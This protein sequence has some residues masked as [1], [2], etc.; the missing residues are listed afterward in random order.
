MNPATIFQICS[1]IALIGWLLLIIVSPFW[2][3]VDKFIISI[4][5]TIFALV[6][7]W[8]IATNFYFGDIQKFNS[9]EGVMSLFTNPAT[10]TAGW[11]HY[12]AFDLMTGLWIKNNSL[13]HGIGHGLVIPCLLLTFMFGPIGLLLYLLLR[14]L[15]TKQY[16]AQNY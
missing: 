8:L 10:V 11:I 1:T 3:G 13:K 14:W 9:L 4:I 5:I 16:F 2:Y 15:I 12:L 6:Y 7:A